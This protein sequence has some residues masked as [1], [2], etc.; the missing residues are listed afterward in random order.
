[1]PKKLQM[2]S[3]D[4]LLKRQLMTLRLKKRKQHMR[5]QPKKPLNLL[6]KKLRKLQM[7]M[8]QFKRKTKYRKPKLHR[9]QLLKRRMP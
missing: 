7:L 4:L 1:M 2:L 5:R 8:I 6:M 9:N 3:E